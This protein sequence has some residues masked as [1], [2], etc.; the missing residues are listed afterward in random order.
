VFHY[1]LQL[2][3]D[4]VTIPLLQHTGAPCEPLVAKG[5]EVKLGQKIGEPK[6]YISAP[7]H[8]SV[9]GVVKSIETV[10]LPTGIKANAVIIENDGKDTPK[11]L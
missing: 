7:V 3:P 8:S 1:N 10:D 11:S 6:G 4:I 9:S 2:A 5:D